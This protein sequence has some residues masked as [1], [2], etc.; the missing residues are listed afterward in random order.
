MY[1]SHAQHLDN[2]ADWVRQQLRASD[3][4]FRDATREAQYDRLLEAV[5]TEFYQDY[6]SWGNDIDY[7]DRI[8]RR[9]LTE[10]FPSK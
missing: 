6:S 2:V 8:V 10:F 7:V 4:E 5:Q 3:A 1:A 9:C